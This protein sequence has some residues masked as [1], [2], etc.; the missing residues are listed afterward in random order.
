MIEL[1]QVSFSYD[2]SAFPVVHDLNLTVQKGELVVI[3]GKS[4]CGKTTVTRI[5]NGL[6]TH[7]YRGA[8]DGQIVIDG[9]NQ[10]DIPFWKIGKRIGAVLQDPS[11]QFF[12]DQAIDE[13]AFGCENYGMERH[14]MQRRISRAAEKTG[15]TALLDQ[16]LYDLSSGQQQRLAIASIYAISPDIYVFDE[17]SANLDSEA[18][19]RLRLLLGALKKEG[20]TVLISEHRLFYLAEVADR[21]VCMKNGVFTKTFSS[22]ELSRLNTD[23]LRWFGL[24]CAALPVLNTRAQCTHKEEAMVIE[25]LSFAY[26][27]TP[28]IHDFSMQIG[29]GEVVALTGPNGAGKT[30]LARILS[31][32]I[33]EK[34]GRILVEHH[35]ASRR[36]RRKLVF[37]VMQHADSQLFAESALE[38][39]RLSAQAPE[40]AET[41]LESYG[42]SPF[43]D[44]HPSTL[45]GGQKQRL[46]LAAAESMKPS[47]LILDEPTSG[48]DGE[49]MRLL[50][51]RMREFAARG[52]TVLVITHDQEFIAL[53]CS[54]LIRL[55][56]GRKIFDK[57]IM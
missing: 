18:V 23:D 11:S 56:H 39:I 5:I 48:L 31:G 16:R 37:F 53:A 34:S 45:S 30:S 29:R 3:T 1:K 42:L 24:R 20:K 32:L 36:L 49:N 52:K 9:Q 4:G 44:A 2:G 14:E 10:H 41:L 54:R 33:T 43:K 15:S 27:K 26:K 35:S 46:L 8:L 22:A 51:A 6:A 28:V 17:P 40:Q 7:F 38:E 55:E 25:H 13:I 57:Q 21:I 47:I 12:A 50:A 19:E